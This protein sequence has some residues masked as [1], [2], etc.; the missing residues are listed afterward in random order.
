MSCKCAVIYLQH[1]CGTSFNYSNIQNNMYIS[2]ICTAT[3]HY[4]TCTVN[5][6]QYNSASANC[7]TFQHI[8]VFSSS[9]TKLN[10][11][12]GLPKGSPNQKYIR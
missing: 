8:L 7:S 9:V 1:I 3:A 4:C 5:V 10:V 2:C 11:G 12:V 6:L